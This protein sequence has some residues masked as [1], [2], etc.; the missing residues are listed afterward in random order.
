MEMSTGPSD[1]ALPGSS[2]TVITWIHK[3]KNCSC[4]AGACNGSRSTDC[5][6]LTFFSGANLLM[7]KLYPIFLE[8]AGEFLLLG[9]HRASHPD[10]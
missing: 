10:I 2:C 8:K 1:E 9:F 3:R 4:V 5:G 7:N 6:P